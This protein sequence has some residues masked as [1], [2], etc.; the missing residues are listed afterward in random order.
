MATRLFA[1]GPD[2]VLERVVE[3]VGSAATSAIINLTVD[4]ATTAITEGGSTRAVKKEEVLRA[5]Q[6]LEAYIIRKDWPPA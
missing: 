1:I 6:T 4:L 3:V 5:I 2:C